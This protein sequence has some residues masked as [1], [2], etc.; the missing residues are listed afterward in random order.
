[1]AWLQAAFLHKSWPLRPLN[2]LLPLPCRCR[3]A[4]K[5]P[6]PYKTL[7]AS[8]LYGQLHRLA[9]EHA[10]YRNVQQFNIAVV[11]PSGNNVFMLIRKK[12]GVLAALH[13]QELVEFTRQASAPA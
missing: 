11:M 8:R 3:Y 10:D 9:D 5:E 12:T 4:E 1:M 7:T 2:V 13:K 6:E